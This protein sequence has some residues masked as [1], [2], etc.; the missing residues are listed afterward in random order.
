MRVVV[1]GGSGYLGQALTERL[2]A[3]GDEVVVLSRGRRRPGDGWRTVPWDARSTGDWVEELEGADAV[4]HLTGRRVDT[5][6]TRRNIDELISSRVE[7]VRAVGEA[8]GLCHDP[9]PVWVQSSSLAIFGDGGD[10]LIDESTTPSGIGPREMVTVCLAWEGAF[11]QAS[12]GVERRV[13]LRMGIGLGGERDPATAKLA[14]LVR[15]GLGGRVGSG[16]QWVSWIGLDDLLRVMVRAIDEPAMHGTYHVT[17]PN[18]VTNAEMMA[19]YRRLLGRRFG[20]PAPTLVARLGAPLLGSSGSLAL[21][22][23]RV[24]PTRLLAEGFDFHQPDFEDTAR[25]AL[26][27]CGRR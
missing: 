26:A 10:R 17:S 16:R 1:P 11:H 3:R 12:D 20:L 25:R 24:V 22:G 27:C 2:V 6:A 19:T 18:P 7:P 4:V 15:L 21:T 8:L 5:R 13:L 14:N 23:R 9:P